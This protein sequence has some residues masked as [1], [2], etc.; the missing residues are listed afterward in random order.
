MLLKEIQEAIRVLKEKYEQLTW[1]QRWFFPSSLSKALDELKD[2]K[3]EHLL[4]VYQAYGQAYF[5]SFWFIQ[6]WFFPFL[7]TFVSVGRIYM[8]V[9]WKGTLFDLPGSSDLIRQ[10]YKEGLLEGVLALDIFSAIAYQVGDV[11]C[12]LDALTGLKKAGLL[13]PDNIAK[14]NNIGNLKNI[15]NSLSE[16][17]HNPELNQKSFD[18][19]IIL[20]R[21]A[22]EEAMAGIKHNDSKD[23]TTNTK[24]SVISKPTALF[25]ETDDDFKW[26]S[27]KRGGLGLFDKLLEESN[28]DTSSDLDEIQR[29]EVTPSMGSSN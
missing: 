8:G 7:N 14:L 12:L 11:E 10:A 16:L 3:L 13:N 19:C 29:Q 22:W 1:F 9:P 28:D 15:E 17:I 25:T 5:G 2:D 18:E 26:C 6:S 20:W 4:P 23:F 27:K 21:Q 24:T